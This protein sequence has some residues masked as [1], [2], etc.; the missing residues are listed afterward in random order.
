MN[1]LCVNKPEWTAAG[2]ADGGLNQRT[3]VVQSDENLGDE[4]RAA[5]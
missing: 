3:V 1:G 4:K 2:A 5:E